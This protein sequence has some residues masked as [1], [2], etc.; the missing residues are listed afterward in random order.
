MLDAQNEKVSGLQDTIRETRSQIQQYQALKINIASSGL[1]HGKLLIDTR[2]INFGYGS[3]LLSQPISFQ[4]RSGE[5][6]QIAGPNGSGKTTLLK[7]ITGEL[8]PLSGN[9]IGTDF[10]YLY[11]D[12]DYSMIDPGLSVYEQVQQYNSVGLEEHA[13]KAMLIYSQFDGDSFDRKCIALSGGEKMKLSLCCLSVSNQTPDLLILDEPT[14]NL[15]VQSLEVLTA[16][17]K[18]YEG[19]LLVISHDEAFTAEIGIDREINL[20]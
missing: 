9:Y 10:S 7:V 2:E 3:P 17:V 14:N 20:S 12:Q 13:I 6:I 1:H 18:G 5:R 19:T 15:D 4:L 16:A 11:L 8:Q